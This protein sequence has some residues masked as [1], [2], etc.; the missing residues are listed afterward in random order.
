MSRMTRS[1]RSLALVMLVM[2]ALMS[3]ISLRDRLLGALSMG[4]ARMTSMVVYECSRIHVCGVVRTTLVVEC[5]IDSWGSC[6]FV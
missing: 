6:F 2:L 1:V 3:L 4:I 5:R